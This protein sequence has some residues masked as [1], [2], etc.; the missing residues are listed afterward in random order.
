MGRVT[1]RVSVGG[2]VTS[3]TKSANLLRNAAPLPHLIPTHIFL[4]LLQEVSLIPLKP[5]SMGVLGVGPR[6]ARCHWYHFQ[7]SVALP[8]QGLLWIY[9]LSLIERAS[10]RM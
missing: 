7:A 3:A 6:I 9:L 2:R 1:P 5:R 4:N 8:V 10:N